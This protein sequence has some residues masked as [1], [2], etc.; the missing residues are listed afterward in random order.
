MGVRP[1]LGEGGGRENGGVVE[2]VGGG[3]KGMCKG[4]VGRGRGAESS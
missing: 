4:E 3:R 1:R 2:G